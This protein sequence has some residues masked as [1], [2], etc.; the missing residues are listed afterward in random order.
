[1]KLLRASPFLFFLLVPSLCRAAQFVDLTAEV[2]IHDWDYWFFSD[3][4]GKY[5]GQEGTPSIFDENR[6]AHCVIGADSWMIETHFPTFNVTRWFTG[7]NIIAHTLIT[8]ETPDSIIKATSEH[9][10]A[11]TSPQVGQTYTTV[12]NSID[13]NPGRPVR[14]ADL[15]GFDLPATTSW[16]AFCSGSAL[17]RERRQIFPPSAFWKESTIA[18]SGWSDATQIFQDGLGLPKSINLVFT[19]GQSIFQYQ[20]RRSTNVLGWNFPLEF[21]A[22]Q[23]LP[24]GTNAWK[25]HMTFRGRVTSIGPGSPLEIPA[26][27]LKSIQK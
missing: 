10:I 14:V 2:E 27:I 8:K 13:G 3:Q 9:A 4:I 18:F 22:V 15:M 12:Q 26:D 23:Y 7:T 25:L 1:M 17:R 11:A 24:V 6:T 16:L 21:Y 19:N 5:P 20:V